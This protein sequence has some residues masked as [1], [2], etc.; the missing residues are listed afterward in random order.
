MSIS[1]LRNS[2]AKLEQS[3]RVWSSETSELA[4]SNEWR[5]Y[6]RIEKSKSKKQEK[7]YYYDSSVSCISRLKCERARTHYLLAAATALPAA[8]D[9]ADTHS[10]VSI[11]TRITRK[12]SMYVRTSSS[13]NSL[14]NSRQCCLR[15]PK[16]KTAKEKKIPRIRLQMPI[17]SKEEERKK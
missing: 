17:V 13:K 9:G 3:Y 5:V 4:I 10:D 1:R 6:F 2:V 11:Y 8:D 16:K 12:L 15:E 7:N 14:Y